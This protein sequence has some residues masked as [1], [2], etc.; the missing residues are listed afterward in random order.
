MQKRV[1][2]IFLMLFFIALL[3]TP[4]LRRRW[5]EHAE[6]TDMRLPD[7]LGLELIAQVKAAQRPERCVA[8]HQN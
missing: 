2:R 6:V 5:Q 3:A 4:T 1:P 8:T 7:G